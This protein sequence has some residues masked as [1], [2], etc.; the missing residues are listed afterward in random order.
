VQARRVYLV[1]GS[2]HARPR[3]VRVEVD[4][5]PTRSVTVSGERLYTLVSL[6]RPRRFRLTLRVPSGV[7]AYAFTFG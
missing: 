1:M 3:A 2:D 7:S 6:P 4:G 5:H